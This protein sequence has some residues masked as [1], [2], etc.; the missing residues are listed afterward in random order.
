MN[1]KRNKKL[2]ESYDRPVSPCVSFFLMKWAVI[3]DSEKELIALRSISFY[4][5]L[6]QA[7]LMSLSLFCMPG[8]VKGKEMCTQCQ[9]P[10]SLI[11]QHSR[12][13]MLMNSKRN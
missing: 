6:G 8:L 4:L 5:L 9:P 10:I 1:E 11:H 3:N 13:H 2:S 12:P 7:T